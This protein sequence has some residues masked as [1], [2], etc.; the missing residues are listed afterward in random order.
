[1]ADKIKIAV[2]PID[3]KEGY[4][5]DYYDDHQY[6]EVKTCPLALAVRRHFNVSQ[7]YSVQVRSNTS[8][9]APREQFLAS[10][11][12]TVRI[13]NDVYSYKDW[14]F[15]ISQDVFNDYRKGNEA[16]HY[17]EL[18]EVPFIG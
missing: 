13:G 14:S 16:V 8:I 5:D 3:F 4:G 2:L 1:M 6:S 17:V 11:T 9:G 7:L 12:G 15:K 10:T 18:T